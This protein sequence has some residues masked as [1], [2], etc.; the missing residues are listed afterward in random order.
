MKKSI[1]AAGA[2]SLLTLVGCSDNNT[3]GNAVEPNAVAE[4]SSSSKMPED[5]SSSTGSSNSNAFSSSASVELM[6]MTEFFTF[7]T[8]PSN[9]AEANHLATE[10]YPDEDATDALC[11]VDAQWLRGVVRVEDNRIVRAFS[12]RNLKADVSDL[13]YTVKKSC[14][15]DNGALI[16]TDTLLV[17]GDNFDYVC[18][19]DNDEVVKSIT[20][21]IFDAAMEENCLQMKT[22]EQLSSTGREEQ[23]EVIILPAGDPSDKQVVDTTLRTLANYAAQYASPKDLNFDKHVMAYNGQGNLDCL[24]SVESFNS[25]LDIFSIARENIKVCFP[26]TDSIIDFS[27][28]SSSCKYYLAR[29]FDTSQ[30]TGH[31]LSKISSDTLEIYNI[32]PAGTCI[33]TN[34]RFNVFFLIEDCEELIKPK[35][36]LVDYSARSSR[37]MC[38][39][40]SNSPSLDAISYGEWYSESLLEN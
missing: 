21:E 9:K 19:T 28:R 12:G 6:D 8:K 22:A 14:F 36:A 11:A 39:E 2:L 5:I 27:K 33:T 17:D 15:T 37:W 10:H 16:R 26:K 35:V 4:N 23:H 13:I 31:V 38:E 24:D 34:E 18:I 3:A 1:I 20:L 32:T 30:P 29:T 7:S 25:G 40:G